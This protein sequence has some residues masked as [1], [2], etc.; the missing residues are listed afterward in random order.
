VCFFRKTVA[1]DLRPARSFLARRFLRPITVRILASLRLPSGRPRV[2]LFPG[3]STAKTPRLRLR[4]SG[5]SSGI[6]PRPSMRFP[7]LLRRASLGR[8]LG[9]LRRLNGRLP[10]PLLLRGKVPG[11]LLRPRIARCLGPRRL[12][13]RSGTSPGRPRLRAS[14]G[15]P[16]AT[17][18]RP[19]DGNSR[20]TRPGLRTAAVSLPHSPLKP[21]GSLAVLPP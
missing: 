8:T 15:R 9:L 19:R 5:R 10:A 14:M 18:P 3:S 13:P 1:K 2:L 7:A 12:R 4:P 16:P 17:L 6:R 21:G 20:R 11:R